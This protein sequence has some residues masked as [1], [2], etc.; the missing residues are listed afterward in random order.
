MSLMIPRKV[1]EELKKRNLDPEPLIVDFLASLLE[2]DPQAAAESHLE[3]AVR[4]LEEGR[5]LI[6]TDPV[7]ASEKIYKAAEEVVK[8]L[9]IHFNL[10]DILEDVEKSGRWSVGKLEKAV[11]SISDK[12]GDWFRSSW[13]TAWALHVWGF[14]EAKFDAEDVRRRL[15]SIDRMVTEAQRIIEKR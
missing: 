11:L 4:Y 10:K 5:K 14:H 8:A 15:P 7:Q 12:V 9:T 1:A 13:D 2:L 6:D 3:L